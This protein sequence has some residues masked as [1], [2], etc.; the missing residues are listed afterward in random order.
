MQMKRFAG[1]AVSLAM[2][3]GTCGCKAST[4]TT[5]T[6]TVSVETEGAIGSEKPAY[7]FAA[8]YV[9]YVGK[10]SFEGSSFDE[11]DASY[12]EASEILLS[13]D[14]NGDGQKIQWNYRYD[15]TCDGEMVFSSEDCVAENPRKLIATYDAGCQKL[16]SGI[17]NFIFYDYNDT[18]FL[19]V[20]VHAYKIAK[21]ENSVLIAIPAPYGFDYYCPKEDT[22][23][24]P[25]TGIALT[26]VPQIHFRDADYQPLHYIMENGNPDNMMLYADDS[27]MC[28]VSMSVNYYGHVDVNSDEAM[29]VLYDYVSQLEEA[30]ESRGYEYSVVSRKVT[31]GLYSLVMITVDEIDKDT[32]TNHWAVTAVGDDDVL[33]IVVLDSDG[34]VSMADLAGMFDYNQRIV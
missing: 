16:P 3:L 30:I 9:A 20:S 24:L 33:Y 23:V 28:R 11:K 22:T 10:A 17:Y 26:L 34:S 13:V 7:A 29:E 18:C 6:T 15:V 4:K 19:E 8:D 32:V 25:G 31:T 1:M 2:V 27:E 12:Y 5:T 14:V 21:S